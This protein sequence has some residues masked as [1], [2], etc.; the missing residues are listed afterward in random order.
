MST[1]SEFP[2]YDFHCPLM[3]LPFAFK[4]QPMDRNK[5]R[6]KYLFPQRKKQPND[7]ILGQ[8][9]KPRIGLVLRGQ[10]KSRP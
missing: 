2:D 5:R 3:S 4:Y 8:T 1:G 9:E 7:K 6:A 10:S